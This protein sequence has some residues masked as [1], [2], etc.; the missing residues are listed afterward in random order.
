MPRDYVATM[1]SKI[2]VVTDTTSQNS[3]NLCQLLFQ[4]YVKFEGNVWNDLILLQQC[5]WR[6]IWEMHTW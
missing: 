6:D 1:S 5:S 2:M 4:D 3:D